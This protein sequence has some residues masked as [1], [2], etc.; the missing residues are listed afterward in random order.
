M[1]MDNRRLDKYI[2]KVINTITVNQMHT[3]VRT[4]LSLFVRYTANLNK[5]GII[6]LMVGVVARN[7]QNVISIQMKN[8]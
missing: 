5:R 6:M 2:E 8:G 3:V 1:I 4:R 7:V